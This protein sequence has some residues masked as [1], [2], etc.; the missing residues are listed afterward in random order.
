MI[1]N[2]RYLANKLGVICGAAAALVFTMV[3]AGNNAFPNV[4]AMP[5]G[6]CLIV[7][8]APIISAV[9]NSTVFYDN[10]P[11]PAKLNATVGLYAFTITLCTLSASAIF[12]LSLFLESATW[13]F[14][15]VLYS[16]AL[17]VFIAYWIDKR[18]GHNS[19]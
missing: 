6:Y 17:G 7:I 12:I 13:R 18:L 10:F 15:I 3:Q 19:F 5:L 8:I 9:A 2:R 1:N 16:A 14:A 11:L 4:D